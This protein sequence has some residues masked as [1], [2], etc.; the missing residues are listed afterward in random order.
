MAT[1][2]PSDVVSETAAT[3][4]AAA[5]TTAAPVTLTSATVAAVTS[6]AL[7]VLVNMNVSNNPSLTDQGAVFGAA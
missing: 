4:A 5:T 2:T 1:A 7:S 3:Q 6:T